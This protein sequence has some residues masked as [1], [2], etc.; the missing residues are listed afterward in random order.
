MRPNNI[1]LYKVKDQIYRARFSS[2]VCD[3][4]QVVMKNLVANL[5]THFFGYGYQCKNLTTF[6]AL[7]GTTSCLRSLLGSSWP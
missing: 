5:A 3:T 1:P 6:G 4:I 7:L 2:A